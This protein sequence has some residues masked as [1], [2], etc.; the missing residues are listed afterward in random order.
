MTAPGTRSGRLHARAQTEGARARGVAS[1]AHHIARPAT[2]PTCLSHPPRKSGR[3]S[4]EGDVVLASL[5]AFPHE[6]VDVFSKLAAFPVPLG[7]QV[8]DDECG[9]V[10]GALGRVSARDRPPPPFGVVAVGVPACRAA[11]LIHAVHPVGLGAHGADPVTWEFPV[12]CRVRPPGGARVD[13]LRQLPRRVRDAG[14]HLRR[15]REG[16]ARRPRPGCAVTVLLPS[17][18][19]Q[20]ERG[21]GS[22]FRGRRRA[23]PLERV[24]RP[25]TAGSVRWRCLPGVVAGRRRWG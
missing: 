25:R 8:G 4:A 16:R 11:R 18:R 14:R 15:H 23:G 12:P 17:R 6:H 2:T 9:G 3:I 7:E 21:T 22:G 19:R 24:C 1:A 20:R 13:R 10:L 5:H